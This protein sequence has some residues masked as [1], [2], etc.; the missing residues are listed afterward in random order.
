MRDAFD[1][2]WPHPDRYFYYHNTGLQQHYV[3]FS[4]SSLTAEATV[5][6]DPNTMS[7]DGTVALSVSRCCLAHRGMPSLGYELVGVDVHAVW[8]FTLFSCTHA[9]ALYPICHRNSC[10]HDP[11][12]PCFVGLLHA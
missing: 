6:L 8:G 12:L 7:D 9:F 11:N 10:T 2:F 5:L 4:Q 3:M 1:F